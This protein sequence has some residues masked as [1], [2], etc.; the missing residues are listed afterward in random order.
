[1]ERTALRTFYAFIASAAMVGCAQAPDLTAGC[2][3]LP[4]LI[5][6]STI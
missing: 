4:R 1:M 2:H 3:L 6:T 5:R